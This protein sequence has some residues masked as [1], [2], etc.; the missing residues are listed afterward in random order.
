LEGRIIV[1]GKLVTRG[2]A[3]FANY[4]VLQLLSPLCQTILDKT[5]IGL[6]AK[7]IKS[8]MLKQLP[9]AVPP[10]A[11]QHWLPREAASS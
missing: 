3:N 8:A 6:T 9:L 5:A 4:M 7:G 10:P 11:A 1:R 2:N